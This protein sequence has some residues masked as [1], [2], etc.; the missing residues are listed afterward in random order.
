MHG[1][2]TVSEI[3]YETYIHMKFSSVTGFC[4]NPIILQLTRKEQ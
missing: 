4:K 2:N 1:K 3:I